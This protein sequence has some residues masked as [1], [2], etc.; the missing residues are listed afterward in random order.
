MHF[1]SDI[2]FSYTCT[3][4]RL[5]KIS[6]CKYRFL[7]D[8]PREYKVIHSITEVSLYK[9]YVVR[10][11]YAT[12][13]EILLSYCKQ[14]NYVLTLQQKRVSKFQQTK[15]QNVKNI[16]ISYNCLPRPCSLL[17]FVQIYCRYEYV[18]TKNYNRMKCVMITVIRITDVEQNTWQTR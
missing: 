15:F 17:L 10:S 5:V 8:S 12:Y 1:E 16:N 2:M 7:L 3:L 11:C 4:M 6:T 18:P 13:V 14:H 9:S